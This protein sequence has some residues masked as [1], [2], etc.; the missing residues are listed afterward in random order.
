[1]HLNDSIRFALQSLTS[2][3]MRTTLT[4]LGIA[5]GIAAVVLLTSLG[6]G[7]HRYVLG[8]FTQFGTN[9]IAITPGRASTTGVSG[10]VISNVRPLS[11]A[12]A[13]AMVKIPW[14]KAVVPVVQ[15][16]AA[17][18]YRR[19]SRRTVIL[20]VGA[21]APVVWRMEISRGQFL[22]EDDGRASRSLVVL[23]A[24][25]GRELFGQTNP[26]GRRVRVGGESCRVI[27]VMAAK[28]QMLG[29]DLDDAVYIPAGRALALFNRDS[30]MEIDLLYAQGSN[31]DDIARRA[32][33]LMMQRHGSE[34]FSVVTQD[35]ML[36][37]LGSVLGVLTMA[38]GALGGISLLVGAVG[39]LTIMTIAVRERT[40]E[41]G[42]LRALGAGRRS[43][44]LL[45]LGEAT[46]LGA[47]GG[48]AGLALGLG[49]AWLLSAVVPAL[50]T[51]TPW[52]YVLLAE[53]LAAGIGLGAGVLPA[54]HAARLDPIEALRAE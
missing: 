25:V 17:V 51:H 16:N 33:A 38:V 11:L 8:E 41:I 44:M 2:Q 37:V 10:A 31:A 26:L 13:R 14:V 27:G 30:L 12:D 45:F 50:P 7:I 49:G 23:G 18:D 47:I 53:T 42:L 9:L 36:E 34:D 21:S 54:R 39:I 4:A 24:T 20:G 43:I 35:Q 19:R 1:M 40:A 29:F 22:P 3:R 6:E 32:K 5:V 15:G 52:S 46:V 28:G 48:A